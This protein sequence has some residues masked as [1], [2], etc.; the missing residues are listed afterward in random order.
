MRLDSKLKDAI[1]E[2]TVVQIKKA[3]KFWAERFCMYHGQSAEFK[4]IDQMNY[5]QQTDLKSCGFF[6]IKAISLILNG[7]QYDRLHEEVS[8][9]DMPRVRQN[10]IDVLLN[11]KFSN[12]L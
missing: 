4:I 12:F 2:A 5:P 6:V 7:F 9:N 3:V 11:K 8:Q 10:L 1:Q